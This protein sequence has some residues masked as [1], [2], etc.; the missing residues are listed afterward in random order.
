MKKAVFSAGTAI[1]LL[2]AMVPIVSALDSAS[3]PPGKDP[4][5][6][7]RPEALALL[8]THIAWVGG[9]QNDRMEGTIRYID[10]ISRGT[11]TV[12]LRQIQDD[13][14]VTAASVPLMRT[15][16]EI[17]QARGDLQAQALLFSNE[18]KKQMGLF[19]GS[20]EGL[21]GSIRVVVNNTEKSGINSTMGPLWLRNESARLTLFNQ[22]SNDRA[23][24]LTGLTKQGVDTAVAKNLSEQIDAQRPALVGALAN[25]SSKALTTTNAVIKN[26]NRQFRQTVADSRA[27]LVIEMKKSAMMAMG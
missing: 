7:D 16:N 27:G 24:I 17:L 1:L 18:A 2:M 21:T 25:K 20:S 10:R 23:A 5:Y 26:L 11:G 19:N 8:K 9:D 14:L 13:Y 6:A 3:L 15:S 22:E 12:N 4:N